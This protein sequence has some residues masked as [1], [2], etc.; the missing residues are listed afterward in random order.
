[1]VLG[2][3]P[4]NGCGDF[5]AQIT[6]PSTSVLRPKPRN[7]TI[8]FEAKPG[9]IINLCFQARRRNQRCSSPYARCRPHTRSPNLSIVWPPSARPVL[10]HP[11]SSIPRLLLLLRSSLL[12]TMPHLSPTHHEISKRVSPHE[13]YSKVEPLK[14][15]G[16]KFKPRQVNYSSQIKP[17]TTWFLNLPLDEYIDNTKA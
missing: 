14:F 16:F 5:K 8:S 3:K 4:R 15:P 12:P 10:D 2:P 11:W 9:E 13:T 17:R 7:R 1:L 6:K